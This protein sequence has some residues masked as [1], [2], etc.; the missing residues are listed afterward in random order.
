MTS[1]GNRTL[2]LV[3]TPRIVGYG[4]TAGY[5]SVKKRDSPRHVP[6]IKKKAA[7][8]AGLRAFE[9]GSFAVLQL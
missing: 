1:K 3:S 9:S 7:F 2:R 5:F 6:S 4:G 8:G